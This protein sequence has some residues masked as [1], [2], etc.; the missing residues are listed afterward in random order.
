MI[1][2]SELKMNGEKEVTVN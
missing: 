1:M 2:N